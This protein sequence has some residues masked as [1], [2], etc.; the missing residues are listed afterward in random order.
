MNDLL[1]A[2][3][4]IGAIKEYNPSANVDLIEKAYHFGLD[5]HEGQ[6]R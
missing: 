1:S 2:D 4:L 3:D 5:A 6:M